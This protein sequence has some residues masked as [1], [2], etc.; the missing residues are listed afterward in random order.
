[1]EQLSSLRQEVAMRRSI[2][3]PGKNGMSALMLALKG[4]KI[5]AEAITVQMH[6]GNTET[7]ELKNNN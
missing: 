7:Q 5:K 3:V 1:M 2:V 4:S 6:Q